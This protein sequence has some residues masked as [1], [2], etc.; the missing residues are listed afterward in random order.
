MNLELSKIYQSVKENNEIKTIST[1]NKFISYLNNS[2][3]D[4]DIDNRSKEQILE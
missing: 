2:I 3:K 4:L 1:L